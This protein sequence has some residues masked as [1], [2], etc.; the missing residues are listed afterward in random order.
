MG[1]RLYVGN[2]PFRST[3]AELANAFAA[4]GTVERVALVTDRETGRPRG[5]AFVEM[6]TEAEAQAAIEGL[7]NQEFQGR[8]L[9]VNLARPR[10]ERPPTTGGYGGGGGYA[11]EGGGGGYARGGGSGGFGRT[12]GGY[13]GGPPPGAGHGAGGGEGRR[14]RR[15]RR[16][17]R[18][19][20]DRW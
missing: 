10:E 9:K 7:D 3:E 5:F 12:G 15:D 17:R 18:D 13:G 4:F 11:R 1:K 8:V 19:D 14:E 16:D 2:M 20:D 6:S